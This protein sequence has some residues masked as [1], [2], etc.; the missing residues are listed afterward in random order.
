MEPHG[1][2]TAPKRIS[3][4][5]VDDH[6]LLRQGVAAVIEGQPDMVLVAEARGGA[7]A[8]EKFRQHQP[9]VTLIDLRMP[10]MSGTQTISE[11]RKQFPAARFIVLTTYK[12][13]AEATAAIRAG[14]AGFLLKSALREDMLETIR[15]VYAGKRRF[16]LE[17]ATEIANHADE[18]ALTEREIEVLRGAAAGKGNK[19][20]ATDLGISTETVKGHMKNILGKLRANDRTHAVMIA[21]RRGVFTL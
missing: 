14:A 15:D 16:P 17:L 12:G 6:P 2:S 4:L 7:E 3:L 1:D 13:D 5:M 8:I 18:D 19:Q 10:G 20:I 21:L 11:I 9:D